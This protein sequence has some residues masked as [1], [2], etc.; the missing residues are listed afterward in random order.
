MHQHNKYYA[1]KIH[2]RLHTKSCI[3][4]VLPLILGKTKIF[5]FTIKHNIGTMK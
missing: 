3:I 5:T 1:M 4:K 2:K